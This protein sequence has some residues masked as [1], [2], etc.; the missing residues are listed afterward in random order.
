MLEPLERFFRR[1]GCLILLDRAADPA[2]N[3]HVQRNGTHVKVF[4]GG[5][6]RSLSDLHTQLHAT[7]HQPGGGDAMAV[8]A[9][10]A[11]G[12]LRTLGTGA[13][14]A[15]AGNHAG[16]GADISARVTHNVDQSIP[17]NAVTTL[18]FNTES[19]DTDAIHDTVTNNSR[20]TCKTAGVYA[21][22]GG[23]RFASNATGRRFVL[24]LL[25]GVTNIAIYSANA[26]TGAQHQITI[27]HMYKLAVNDYIEMQVLQTSGAALNAETSSDHSPMFGMMKVLG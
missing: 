27:S 10:A 25:N 18:A 11:T 4:S 23:L 20:L 6:V 7:A 14:Q 16:G 19:F 17:N 3:G 26:D 1:V 22:F 24:I 12:S 21:I 2:A 13:L 5:A 8:D 9:A 15:A